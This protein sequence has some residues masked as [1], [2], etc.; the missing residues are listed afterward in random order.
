MKQHG[1]LPDGR[2]VYVLLQ[3][4]DSLTEAHRHGL[5]HRDITY[6]N[7]LLCRLANSCDFVKVLDFGL[8][9]DVSGDPL[10]MS[11]SHVVAGTAPFLSPEAALG[12]QLDVRAD[13]YSFGC[14]AYW[15]LTGRH[16]FE[17]TNGTEIILAHVQKKPQPPSQVTENPIPPALEAHVLDCLEKKTPARPASIQVVAER[18][19][20]AV[21]EV[22]DVHRADLWWRKHQ[23]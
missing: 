10:D 4:C 23:P 16:V 22:W 1:P 5:L 3:I 9:K 12:H 18:L 11:S 6:R 14:L 8:V 15:L 13:I 17:E 7:V 20:C 19:G 21:K 2:V